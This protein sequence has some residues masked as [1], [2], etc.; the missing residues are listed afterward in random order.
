[1]PLTVMTAAAGG[2]GRGSGSGSGGSDDGGCGGGSSTGDNLPS[3]NY[4][5][6]A[7]QRR[8]SRAMKYVSMPIVKKAGQPREQV[9]KG[10]WYS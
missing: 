7:W 1:M 9:L 3:K 5:K 8:A 6:D 4:N 10:N 2:S